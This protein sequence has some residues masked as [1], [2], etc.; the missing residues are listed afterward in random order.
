MSSSGAGQSSVGSRA[1]YEAGDQRNVP[2]SEINEQNRYAEG[3]KNSHKNL[4]S[5][6]QRSIGN[7]LASQERK[8]ESDHHHNFDQNPEAELSKQDPTKPAKVHGNE[9][10]KGAKIDAEL[11]AE[12]EQ[13]L[14][15]KGIKK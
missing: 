10:S 14:R 3:Q 8:P 15:E 11:Q 1:I 13:R 5:K 9:P 6:D 12:D 2:Q 7:K 4:D